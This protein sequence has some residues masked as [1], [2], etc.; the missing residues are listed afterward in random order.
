MPTSFWCSHPSI[1]PT[2]WY[3][4]RGSAGSIAV[5]GAWTWRFITVRDWLPS[6]NTGISIRGGSDFDLKKQTR[7]QLSDGPGDTTSRLRPLTAG[8]CI[9]PLLGCRSMT[10]HKQ[11]SQDSLRLISAL[12]K[13]ANGLALTLTSL[14]G[15]LTTGRDLGSEALPR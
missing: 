2:A 6:H 11:S 4:S 8:T 12:D 1:Y 13:V 9:L 7:P 3:L 15:R 14:R 5:L 10:K